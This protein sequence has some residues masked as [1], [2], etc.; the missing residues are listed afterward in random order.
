MQKGETALTELG[1]PYCN[2]LDA[3]YDIFFV[4]NG[5]TKWRRQVMLIRSS[6]NY[7]ML[8]TKGAV[9]AQEQYIT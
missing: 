9:G 2:H 5:A 3:F 7:R 8:Q 4:P 1:A 6:F